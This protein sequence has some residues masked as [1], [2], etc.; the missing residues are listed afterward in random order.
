M[1][2]LEQSNSQTIIPY[3][4]YLI[5]NTNDSNKQTAHQNRTTHL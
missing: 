5:K 4:S 3:L 2:R 1:E